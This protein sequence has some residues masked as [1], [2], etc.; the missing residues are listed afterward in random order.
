M[1]EL[2]RSPKQ[3]GVALRRFRRKKKLTQAELAKQAGVRQGTIS[4]VE[5]GLETVK[6]T[7][8]MDLLRALDLEMLLQPRTKG[9]LS[10][11][12]ELY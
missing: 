10:D 3:V 1:A 12:E 6:L 9:S 4:Q 2:I 7:T 5:N 11:I 8:V